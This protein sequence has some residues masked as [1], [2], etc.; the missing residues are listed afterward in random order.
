[1]QKTNPRVTSLQIVCV[2]TRPVEGSFSAIIRCSTP[3]LVSSAAFL[4][5]CLTASCGADRK[6]SERL[7][8]TRQALQLRHLC[9]GNAACQIAVDVQVDL[10]ASF[11]PGDVV[12]AVVLALGDGQSYVL[13]T[14]RDDLG[15]VHAVS[16]A[17]GPGSLIAGCPMPAGSSRKA[18]R[19]AA[20]RCC[21]RRANGANQLGGDA[22]PTYSYCRE[23]QGGQGLRASFSA[24]QL[25]PRCQPSQGWASQSSS[26][27][28]PLSLMP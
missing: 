2:D 15:V 8:S 17:G 1:M 25:H 4:A 6:T 26:Q 21:C 22:V 7:R 20:V 3:R 18:S 23:A 24:V 13:T 5:A 19:L 28:A 10:Y 9:S 11:R 12:R 27:S 14:A 16:L